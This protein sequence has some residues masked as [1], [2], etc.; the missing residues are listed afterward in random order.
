[1]PDKPTKSI[2][3]TEKFVHMVAMHNGWSLNQDGAFL[4]SL[5]EGLTVNFNRYGFYQCPCRDSWGDREKDG[6][7][8]CPCDYN[9][10]DQKEY[11]HCFCGL[12][13]TREFAASGKMPSQIPERRPPEKF[14]D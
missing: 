8:A 7:I 14:P 6:D 5:V 1:M 13:L 4:D 3:D 9:R 11:G 10:P 12:F 2:A